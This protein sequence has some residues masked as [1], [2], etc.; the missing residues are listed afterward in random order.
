MSPIRV[1]E[2]TAGVAVGD[3]LGGAARFIIE[4]TK[5]FDRTRVEPF[6]GCLW[7]YDSPPEAYWSKALDAG[8][9]PYVFAARWRP[10]YPLLSCAAALRGLEPLRDFKPDI[11]HS[12]GEFTDIA[13]ILLKRRLGARYLVRTRHSTI[14]WPKRPALGR[15]FGHWIYPWLFDVEVAVSNQAAGALNQRPFARF[16]RRK[17]ICIY[18]AIDFGRFATAMQDVAPL[19]QEL[20][21]PENAVVLGSVGA[22]S[23]VKGYDILLKAFQIVVATAPNVYLLIVG[24]GPE[25]QTLQTLARA[26]GVE[27]RVRFLGAQPMI[28]RLYPIFDLFVSSSRVE[29]LPTVL[30]ESIAAGVPVVATDIPGSREIIEN[31]V[32][33]LLAPPEDPEALA[34]VLLQALRSPQKADLFAAAAL[35][36]VKKLFAIDAIAEQYIALFYHLVT[37]TSNT[38]G[39]AFLP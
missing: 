10:E 6:L 31:N 9:I 3:P 15:I 12:H 36:R 11:V 19:K 33:G 37:G 28:E 22:L 30:L 34:G 8:A 23:K 18:N 13:A 26:L 5:A 38:R 2:L 20:A 16:R 21:I 14:E 35:Q 39:K 17:A 4:L 1:L 25:R 29:G 24:D 27:P 32:T 7:R